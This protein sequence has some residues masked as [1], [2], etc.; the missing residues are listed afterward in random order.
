M[1]NVYSWALIVVVVLAVATGFGRSEG[2]QP[3][4]TP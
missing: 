3:A 4:N 2:P 1:H